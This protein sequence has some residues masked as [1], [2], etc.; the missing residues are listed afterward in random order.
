MGIKM[1]YNITTFKNVFQYQMA[2]FNNVKPQLLSCHPNS[3]IVTQDAYNSVLLIKHVMF[4]NKLLKELYL[5][6]VKYI[7]SSLTQQLKL[8]LIMQHISSLSIIDFFGN[9]A[10]LINVLCTVAIS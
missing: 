7:V 1:M 5:Y 9:R 2:N 8:V 6:G 4:L 10:V 3:F